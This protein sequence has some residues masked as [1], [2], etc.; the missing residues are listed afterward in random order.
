MVAEIISGVTAVFVGGGRRTG[1]PVS[2]SG[3]R[4]RGGR[5]VGGVETPDGEIEPCQSQRPSDARPTVWIRFTLAN[6]RELSRR[7]TGV[8][9]PSPE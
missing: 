3:L 4:V 5:P 2:R 7:T 1:F 6:S 8:V 9:D